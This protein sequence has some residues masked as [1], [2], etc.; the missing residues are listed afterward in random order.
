MVEND[1][2]SLMQFGNQIAQSQPSKKDK[3][4]KEKNPQEKKLP[5]NLKTFKENLLKKLKTIKQTFHPKIH[6]IKFLKTQLQFQLKHK[7]TLKN[8]MK[9]Q[10][11]SVKKKE[12]ISR[13]RETKKQIGNTTILIRR[14]IYDK[15]WDQYCVYDNI[16]KNFNQQ[17]SQNELETV[18]ITDYGSFNSTLFD[19]PKK[20]D[21]YKQK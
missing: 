16:E 7:K 9:Q 11:V 6:K 19:M 20:N 2:S 5:H 21:S 18:N 12:K 13:I 10:K 15:T 8:I 1:I 14:R 17:P 3:K 4:I